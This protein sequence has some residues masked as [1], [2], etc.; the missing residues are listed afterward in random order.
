[1]RKSSQTFAAALVIAAGLASTIATTAL[2]DVAVPQQPAELSRLLSAYPGVRHDSW[3][4]API[5]FYGVPMTQAATPFLAAEQW[6]AEFDGAFSAGDLELSLDRNDEVNYGKF[7]TVVYH[8]MMDGLPVEFGAV[9]L[10]VL[11]APTREN[12]AELAH[13]VVMASAKVAPR[14]TGGFAP[15][16]FSA[17]QATQRAQQ[18]PLSKDLDTWDAPTMCVFFG[19]GDF[20]DRVTPVRCWKFVGHSSTNADKSYTFFIDAATNRVVHAR[21]NISHADIIGRIRAVATPDNNRAPSAT[22]PPV[23]RFIPEIRV[24][25][26][27]EPGQAYT[28]AS[29]FFRI[30]RPAT[31]TTPAMLRVTTTQGHWVNVQ[32]FADEGQFPAGSGDEIDLT[33]NNYPANS[34]QIINLTTV[35][36]QEVLS[37]VDT[38]LATNATHTFFRSRSGTW[39]AI[40]ERLPAN[41]MLDQTCNAFFRSAPRSINFFRAGGGC[42]NTG[43]GNVVNHEYG[44]YIVY[45]LNLGQGAFGEGFGDVI[46][47]L[48]NDSPV[49]GAGFN[50]DGSPVRDVDADD[51]QYPCDDPFF[52]VHYCGEILGG[53]VWEMRNAF[54]QRFGVSSGLAELRQL[55]VDWALVTSG[56]RAEHPVDATSI[57]EWLAV[58]DTDGFFC[59]G[60]PH[61]AQILAGFAAR[62]IF[63]AGDPFV[64]D[65]VV[66]TVPAPAPQVIPTGTSSQVVVNMVPESAT[67]VP[68]SHRLQYRTSRDGGWISVPMTPLANNN[69]R[70]QLPVL[71]CTDA[72]EYQFVVDT[73]RGSVAFPSPG[74]GGGYYFQRSQPNPI[75]L[76][77]FQPDNFD[78]PNA[79][80]TESFVDGAVDGRW[81]RAVPNG[82]SVVGL[83]PSQDA[84]PDQDANHPFCWVTE[85][86]PLDGAPEDNDVDAG[87]AVLTTPRFDLSQFTDVIVKYNR[88]FSNGKGSSPFE[89]IFEVQVSDDDGATWHPAQTV[90]PSQGPG[91]VGTDWVA[92]SFTLKFSG[93]HTSIRNRFR[94]VARDD[95]S[96]SLVEAGIDDFQ[97]I[98]S[99]CQPACDSIDFNRDGLLPD[100][101]DIADFISVFGGGGCSTNDCADIDFNNDGLFPDITDIDALINA[102]AGGVCD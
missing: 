96:D 1:M 36:T 63:P 31:A 38:L 87:A 91:T 89:D 37:Q 77:E 57:P 100:T 23:A 70:A 21:N 60:T 98:G 55:F 94:F 81:I 65:R 11:N 80:W 29:G 82:S 4:G 78:G 95:F 71:T 75:D 44:H 66:I 34:N 64:E 62:N 9:R 84:T 49:I 42:T 74:C 46:A 7:N 22:N 13:R 28:D 43:W 69:F 83:V 47:M 6:L 2:A 88:W 67:V 41:V 52:E 39:D 54:V 93:A 76:V 20:S 50:T 35:G 53:V 61:H 14:P 15:D 97:I 27:G 51:V 59:T 90:G 26:V 102:F 25:L 73:D 72:I 45:R 17:E 10:L 58:D 86:N 5:N 12:P 8:Q 101:Q 3:K 48:M 68:G 85:N 19:E 99:L 18:L 56:G 92:S 32:N 40:D 24:S 79:E 30:T 33:V 16:A